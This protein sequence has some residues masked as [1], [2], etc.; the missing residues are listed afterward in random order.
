MLA[1]TLTPADVQDTVRA[2]PGVL[3]AATDLTA[4][5]AAISPR[6]VPVLNNLLKL[7]PVGPTAAPLV[8][9][10]SADAAAILRGAPSYAPV[11]RSVIDVLVAAPALAPQIAAVTGPMAAFAKRA[12][13]D[14]ALGQFAARLVQIIDLAR[15][16]GSTASPPVPTAPTVE[17]AP[18]VGLAKLLPWMDR[19]ITVMR[20]PW[21]LAAV[22]AAILAVVG[23]V[24]YAIG[25]R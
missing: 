10:I 5:T 8:Q 7:L 25:R 1:A 24:G 22:P 19:T 11:I 18:G 2:L 3:T 23:G 14:P 4:K 9:R 17:L 13:A 15:G 16:P 6:A 12:S 21:L 20:H